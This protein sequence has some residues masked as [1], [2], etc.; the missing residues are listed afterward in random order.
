MDFVSLQPYVLKGLVAISSL[1]AIAYLLVF[2]GGIASGISPCYSPILLMFGSYVGGFTSAR[3]RAMFSIAIPFIG[4]TIIT[5]AVVGMVAGAIGSGVM[6][7]F[8]GL[9]LD[10]YIPGL[11]GL[12]M[13]FQLLGLWQLKLPAFQG[14]NLPKA[15]GARQA[16]ALGLPFGLVITPCTVPIFLAVLGFAVGKASI[17]YGSTLMIAYALGRGLPLLVVGFSANF[18][19]LFKGRWG[20]YLEKLAGLVILLASIYVLFIR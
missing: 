13:G 16:L 6:K 14:F 3:K 15:S 1:S 2:L 4:G 9:S 20:K 19:S 18:L 11:L 5:M 12:V 17:I 8:T 10:R 7:L